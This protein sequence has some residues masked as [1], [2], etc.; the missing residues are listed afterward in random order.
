MH[1][2]TNAFIVLWTALGLNKGN[3][4]LNEHFMKTLNAVLELDKLY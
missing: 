2:W 3:M 4:V 1:E